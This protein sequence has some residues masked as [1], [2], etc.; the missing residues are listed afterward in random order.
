MEDFSRSD[1]EKRHLNLFYTY[2]T[3]HLEDNVTRALMLTL[4]SLAPVHLRLFLRDVILKNP[5]QESLRARM[6]VFTISNFDFDLQV[7]SPSKPD[8]LDLMNGVIVGIKYSGTVPLNFSQLV[9]K[10]GGSR[11]DALL[12]DKA[13]EIAV[14]F[15]TKLS[16]SLYQ[17]QIER[18]F[19]AFFNTQGISVEQIYI[20]ITWTEIADFLQRVARQSVSQKEQFMALEFVQY[21]DWLKL[22]GFLGFSATDFSHPQDGSFYDRKLDNF[23]AQMVSVQGN[24]LGLKEYERNWM[25]YFH[26]VPNENVWAEMGQDGVSLGIVAGSGKM[27]RA[28]Q[29]RDFIITQPNEIRTML[30][31]LRNSI[32]PNFLITLRVHSYFR[33]SR[34]RTAWLGDISGVKTYPIDF[35]NFVASLKTRERMFLKKFRRSRFRIALVRT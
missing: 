24:Q 3:N 23:L 28:K 15:E 30:D 17:E 33:H 21:L 8:R 25:L 35:E 19:Q 2:H 27:W 6:Q 12:S 26:D 1:F 22:V 9:D 31:R 13:N 32:D 14:I 11:P 20:E 10:A 34:F 29:L 18:H 5:A 4:R 16:N 7:T